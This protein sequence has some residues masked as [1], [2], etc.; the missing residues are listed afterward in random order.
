MSSTHKPFPADLRLLTGLRAFAALMV[1]L[2]HF[3]AR[4]APGSG[5]HTTLIDRGHLGV[6]IFFVLSGFILAHVYLARCQAGQFK[7]GQ[8][9][10]NRFARLYP[11]HLAMLLL[12]AALGWRAMRQGLPLAVYGPQLGLDPVTGDGFWC[13]LISHLTLTHAWGTTSGYAFNAVSWSIS[14]EAAAYLLFPVIAAASLAFGT[15]PLLRM[16]AAVAL[17]FA[18]EVAAQRVLGASLNDLTW[19]FGIL[20]IL[21]EFALGVAAYG[22]GIARPIPRHLLRW[23]APAALALTVTLLASG[24]PALLMPPLFAVLILA[25]ASTE[26]EH[27]LPPAWLLNPLIYLG[28]ISY[29]TYMLHQV[30]GNVLFNAIARHRNYDPHALPV[31]LVVAVVVL[32]LLASAATYHLIEL[33]GRTLLRGMM[34]GSP[35]QTA[36]VASRREHAELKPQPTR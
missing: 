35:R 21:P 4:T 22:L 27:L 29:S 10:I 26:R 12:A 24:A 5:L 11:M 2:Y 20:R 15:R 30:L 7:A 19:R 16:A 18:A 8:F 3:A 36:S 9:L 25:I 34:R 32:I 13:N 17:Y 28:E 14:A 33:P 6:D 1:V 23:L 31:S